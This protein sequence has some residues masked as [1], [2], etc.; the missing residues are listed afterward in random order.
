MSSMWWRIPLATLVLFVLNVVVGVPLAGRLPK[1]PVDPLGLAG[2]LLLQAAV[3][4]FVAVRL[5]SP[6]SRRVALL[7]L[8]PFAMQ[9]INLLEAYVF[10]IDV[11]RE[12]FPALI[13][14][15]LAVSALFALALDRIAGKP[16]D[17]AGAPAARS[18]L[19]WTWRI[20]AS[21]V[22]YVVVYFSAG[23]LVWPFVQ[24]FYAQRPMPAVETIVQTQLFRGL[25]FTG[26]VWLL[27]RRLDG[28]RGMR[29]LLAG[30]TLSIVGGVVPLLSPNPYMPDSIRLPHLVEVGVSN[31]LFGIAVALLLTPGTGRRRAA[32]SIDQGSGGQVVSPVAR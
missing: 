19:D 30:V 1:V 8:V 12:H 11:P 2:G 15:S 28:T 4:A 9:A 21:D 18:A 10:R 26:L 3:L 16:S 5:P 13:L 22:L 25:V 20:A 23:M 14:H 6:R 31:L 32:G 7:F 24:H 17:D 29:A 27:A